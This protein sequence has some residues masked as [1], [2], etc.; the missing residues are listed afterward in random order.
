[1]DEAALSAKLKA[2]LDAEYVEVRDDSDGCGA[3]FDAIIVSAKFDGMMLL[4]RQRAVNAVL[5]EEMK[6]IHALTMK[7][8]TPAQAQQ[9]LE[10]YDARKA[11]AEAAAE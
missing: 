3:K 10:D 1:M 5:E 6:T 11:A 9:K 8:W 7:T 4:Q 2:E